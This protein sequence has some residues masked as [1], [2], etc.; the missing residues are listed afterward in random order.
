MPTLRRRPP[1]YPS[2]GLVSRPRPG[3]QGGPHVRRLEGTAQWKAR[4]AGARFAVFFVCGRA[5]A[6]VCRRARLLGAVAC[7]VVRG[8]ARRLRRAVETFWQAAAKDTIRECFKR[9][10]TNPNELK[11]KVQALPPRPASAQRV[12][13][14]AAF[15]E[16]HAVAHLVPDISEAVPLQDFV[17]VLR[18]FLI[19]PTRSLRLLAMRSV[20]L[21]VKTPRL[22]A[23]FNKLKCDY[24]LA[25]CMEKGKQVGGGGPWLGAR[26]GLDLRGGQAEEERTQ[27]FKVVKTFLEADPARLPRAVIQVAKAPSH[28]SLRCTALLGRA[29]R[30]QP[31]GAAVLRRDQGRPV[32]R[33]IGAAA[34]RAGGA[35]PARTLALRWHQEPLHHDGASW[36]LLGFLL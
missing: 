27:A 20:Q 19:N 7:C 12:T 14:V 25:R 23:T 6:G 36:L 5:R 2:S 4:A 22:L 17:A 34:D 28:Q 1:C 8:V 11:D 9:L 16:L 24:L 33:H 31:T 18:V 29:S 13:Q 26:C 10:S 3:C 30:Q 32:L 21:F 15:G 35:Q